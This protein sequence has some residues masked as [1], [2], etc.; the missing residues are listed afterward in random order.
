[1]LKAK[2]MTKARV[3]GPKGALE[4]A[5]R[6]LYST[7]LLHLDDHEKDNFFDI[8]EPMESAEFYSSQIVKV[9]AMVSG[10]GLKPTGNERPIRDF[11]GA[12][13]IIPQLSSEYNRLTTELQNTKDELRAL[14]QQLS[15]LLPISS[16][17]LSRRLLKDYTMLSVLVGF[18]KK[19]P[20]R[21]LEEKGLQFELVEGTYGKK[22]VIALY[23]PLENKV[24]AQQILDE[25]GFSQ[26][27]LPEKEFVKDVQ[28]EIERTTSKISV[29]ESKISAF[30]KK[31]APFLLGY[32]TALEEENSKAMA[33]VRFASSRNAFFATGWVPTG[34]FETLQRKLDTISRGKVFVE[35]LEGGKGAPIS[36]DNPGPAK[37]FEFFMG[38]YSLPKYHEIDPTALMA[39]TFPL[40]FGFILG[41]I[42]YGI[43]CLAAFLY[44]RGKMQGEGRK[45]LTTLVF[46][47]IGTILFGLA[48]A[49]FFGAE[50]YH[51]L[52]N[53][54]HDINTMLMVSIAIGVFHLNLGFLLGF[55]N[56]LKH[57][58]F[59]HAFKEKIS[60]ILLEIGIALIAIEYL[61]L[62]E[63]AQG[64]MITGILVTAAGLAYLYMGEGVRGIVELPG[65]LSNTLSYARLFAVGL[66]SVQLAI[67]VNTFAGQFMAQGGFM[68]LAA[69]LVILLGHGINILLGI[70]G[71]FLHSMRLHYVE[72]FTKFFEG[73]GKEY[74]PFGAK[75]N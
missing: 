13:S 5:V 55:Y 2:R 53:R 27:T 1:M 52:I 43:V 56:V 57:H 67:V 42:G 34:K 36:L 15:Q 32:Q 35:A 12:A 72:F 54:A 19:S 75:N 48:F 20:R 73:G 6:E 46:S 28:A 63:G 59:S 60:W 37:P 51:P 30:S 9:N 16:L 58:G 50:I 38:L 45:L 33:P 74:I 4:Q 29:L 8:G 41:D 11:K 49:E 26:L 21:I 71:G 66:A 18:V 47:A 17:G 61:S 22:Q 24:A 25:Q 69:I 10:L 39:F 31:N 7:G 3:V 23:V 14:T 65:L 44:L 40:F 70:L 62:I 64:L 68:I